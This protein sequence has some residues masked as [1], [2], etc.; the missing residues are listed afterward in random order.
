MFSKEIETIGQNY[1]AEISK[2]NVQ[3]SN[4]NH[5]LDEMSEKY[6]KATKEICEHESAFDELLQLS[7]YNEERF[8]SLV[9]Q[10]CQCSNSDHTK[11]SCE[12]SKETDF[13]SV[14]NKPVPKDSILMYSDE[15]GKNMGTRLYNVSDKPVC[16]ICMPGAAIGEI[17]DKVLNCTYD[18]AVRP[19]PP[20]QGGPRV[21][22]TLLRDPQAAAPSSTLLCDAP[23]T[24]ASHLRG[25]LNKEL[26]LELF[27]NNYNIDVICITE[28]WLKE[29][30]IV[31][32]FEKH[33]VASSFSR[34][35]A[36]H[37]GSLII[38]KRDL[39]LKVRKD[40]VSL[41]I[42]RTIELACVEL[43]HCI[44]VSI[45]R[46][47]GACYEQ[48]ESVLEEVIS[49]LTGECNKDIMTSGDFN[50]NLL[51]NN[52]LSKIFLSLFKCCNLTNLFLEPT[53]ITNSTATCIDNIFTDGTPSY[54]TIINKLPS[55]HCG[56]LVGFNYNK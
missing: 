23:R 26:E 52:I 42:E 12:I 13:S 37:G 18:P 14:V 35:T 6:N 16:N 34:K 41:S 45:Y 8:N 54:S 40:I 21:P 32:N 5:N 4:L 36:I 10:E 7:R 17:M 20:L 22:R 11:P 55:D 24:F 25:L 51:D 43:T 49:K 27:L 33:Q 29:Y 2:L 30:Q 19:H 50:I 28:H 9:N 15:L 53:R 46:P 39:K 38:V 44:I 48:F 47:P 31:F 3:I 56:Q 1:E